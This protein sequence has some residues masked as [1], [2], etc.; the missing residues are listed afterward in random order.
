AE[1]D[2]QHYELFKSPTGYLAY[3]IVGW[4]FFLGPALTAPVLMLF[5]S[6]PRKFSLL[7]IQP[8]TAFLL[9]EAA[10]VL[11]GSL[12]VIYYSPH[13]SAPASGLILLLVLLAMKQMRD[14]SPSGVFLAR[15]ISVICVLMLFIRAAAGPLGIQVHDFYEFAWHEKMVRSFG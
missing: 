13:Y 2:L 7:K 3:G 1:Q 12:L 5:F 9:F 15:A 10:V 8:T 14:W 6:L 4:R 11:V